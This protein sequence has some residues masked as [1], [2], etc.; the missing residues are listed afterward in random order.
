[1]SSSYRDSTQQTIEMAFQNIDTSNS[2]ISAEAL[3]YVVDSDLGKY[4]VGIYDN[5][6]T[7]KRTLI[8]QVKTRILASQVGNSYISNIYIIPSG[9]L[10]MISTKSTWMRWRLMA[11]WDSGM[12]ITMRWMSI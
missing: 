3:K 10:Q 11:S 6:P 9:D 4:F 8:D 7:S 2:F 1:M 5:D 12:T